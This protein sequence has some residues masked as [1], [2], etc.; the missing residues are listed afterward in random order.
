MQIGTTHTIFIAVQNRHKCR[1]T[2]ISETEWFE[3][4]KIWKGITNRMVPNIVVRHTHFSHCTHICFLNSLWKALSQAMDIFIWCSSIFYSSIKTARAKAAV[5]TVQWIVPKLWLIAIFT[6]YPPLY[7]HTLMGPQ[8]WQTTILM[9]G[10][11]DKLSNN[12]KCFVFAAIR[13]NAFC[14]IL[15]IITK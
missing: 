10:A 8:K 4:S 9:R 3:L 6:Y 5:G 13:R 11:A 1:W 12:Q 14:L 2:A 7:A 15:T